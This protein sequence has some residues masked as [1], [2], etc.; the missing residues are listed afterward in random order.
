[1]D[2]TPSDKVVAVMGVTGSGKSSFIK[3]L[4]GREDIQVGH[5][6]KS[7]EVSYILTHRRPYPLTTSYYN[8]NSKS[9]AV[10]LLAPRDQFCIG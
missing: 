5:T 1:M 9:P 7:G 3:T 2:L 4:T 8:R 6:L 10:P